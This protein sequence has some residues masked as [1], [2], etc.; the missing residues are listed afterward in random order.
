MITVQHS[1]K[2]DRIYFKQ[3]MALREA[4]FDVSIV[5]A[6]QDGL[7]R[8]MSGN[9]VETGMDQLGI[10]HLVV[11]EPQSTIGRLAKKLYKGPFYSDFIAT[12]CGTDSKTFIAHEPQSILVARKCAQK[13][14][15]AY[16]FDSHES[17]HLTSPK[18]RYAIRKEMP[19]M[20]FFTSANS[21]TRE[22][23]L[24]L[25][26]SAISEVIYAFP[27]PAKLS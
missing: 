2:D 1:A 27:F 8:D 3:A 25:N 17:L 10:E 23:I 19:V 14:G 24:K 11:K 26:P 16:V 21:L 18:D 13:N 15:G 12:A 9:P 4:G 5:H 20:P 6:S 7:L 22:S